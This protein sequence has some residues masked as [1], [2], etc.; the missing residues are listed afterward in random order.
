MKLAELTPY[1]QL[2][3]SAVP[4]AIVNAISETGIAARTYPDWYE[5]G[6]RGRNGGRPTPKEVERWTITTTPSC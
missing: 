5:R 1:Q 3:L 6:A 4:E 2:V